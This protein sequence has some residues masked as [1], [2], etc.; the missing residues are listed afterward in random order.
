MKSFSDPRLFRVLDMLTAPDGPITGS[1]KTQW[2]AHGVE[3]KRS[4]HSCTADG[5]HFTVE[6]CQLTRQAQRGWAAIV[7]KE[8]W[9]LAKGPEL[10]RQVRW[11]K[12]T[13]GRRTDALDWFRAREAEIDQ[14][15]A[16]AAA[17]LEHGAGTGQ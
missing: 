13:A 5:Y 2:A 1:L 14:R 17:N 11:A 16:A 6:V 12:L 7:V 9:Q 15:W 10:P 3:F 8:Y 4:K